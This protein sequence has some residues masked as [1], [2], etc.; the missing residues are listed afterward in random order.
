M[1][2]TITELFYLR[3]WRVFCPN[4]SLK[5]V[6][7]YY[8]S[9]YGSWYLLPCYQPGKICQLENFREPM[10]HV[11]GFERDSWKS[12]DSLFS[13]TPSYRGVGGLEIVVIPKQLYLLYWNFLNFPNKYQNK[14]VGQN[15]NSKQDWVASLSRPIASFNLGLFD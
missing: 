9:Y 6:F 7:R 3:T 15:S 8:V 1:F 5:V 4:G 2:W 12:K 13:L 14:N 10:K 11:T